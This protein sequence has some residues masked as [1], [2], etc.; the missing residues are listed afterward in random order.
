MLNHSNYIC[1]KI[2]KDE[3]VAALLYT[4][5]GDW[6]DETLEINVLDIYPLVQAEGYS[7]DGSFDFDYNY[8]IEQGYDIE[9]MRI[10]LCHSH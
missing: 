3:W 7:F 6:L 8:A 10:G 9:N 4:F 1:K 2:N 5:T